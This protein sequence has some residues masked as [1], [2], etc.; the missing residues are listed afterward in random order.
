MF[1]KLVGTALLTLVAVGITFAAPAGEV[2]SEI[3]IEAGTFHP[4]GSGDVAGLE[5]FK[6]IVE[7]RS[8]G[9]ITVNISFGEALGGELDS[10]EQA[11]LGTFHVVTDGLGTM[12]RYA[13]AYS[14]WTV[15]YAYPDYETL[16]ASAK[17]PIGQAIAKKMEADGLLFGGLIPMGFRNMTSNRRAIEPET[18]QGM[19]LRLPN[20]AMWITV[21]EKFGVI[22]TPVPAPEIYL[23]LQ[24]GLVEAQE[25]PYGVI[26]VRKFWEVQDYVIE[27]GHIVDFHII[28]LNKKFIDGLD[29]ENR[30]LILK[31]IDD[32]VS[33]QTEHVKGL[34]LKYKQEAIDNGMEIIQPNVAAY[35]RIAT[36]AW[37]ILAK[38]WEP[39]VYDQMIAE[40]GE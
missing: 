14:A 33:W 18:I 28:V 5:Y 39:W 4:R 19:K 1:K 32:T 8:G 20:N 2:R 35:R 10:I 27:T 34:Q 12:G 6:E 23:G 36:A 17:G 7:E 22:P 3:V 24:T 29:S 13:Q 37:P 30:D 26:H 31:A 38:D 25:N 9:A 16:Q 11:R 15:P 40:T 21:W